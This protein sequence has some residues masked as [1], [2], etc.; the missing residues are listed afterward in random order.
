MIR[1]LIGLLLI[2]S[3]ALAAPVA[4]FDENGTPQVVTFYDRSANTPLYSSRSDCIVNPTITATA[5]SIS[6]WKH[7]RGSIVNMTKAE[8]DARSLAVDN[9]RIDDFNLSVEEAFDAFFDVYNSKVTTLE[10]VTKQ[11]VIDKTKELR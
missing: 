1:I 5:P 7:N 10:R 9:A 2:S 11:E 8:L 3:S 4:C 6:D